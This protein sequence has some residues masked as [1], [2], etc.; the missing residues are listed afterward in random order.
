MIL[1]HG[2]S[3]ASA[4]NILSIGFSFEHSGKNWGST[5]GKGIYFTPNYETARCYAGN[6]GIVMQFDMNIENYYLL[7][8]LQR[9]TSKKIKYSSKWLITPDFDEYIMLY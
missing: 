4:L 1:Y 5:Y 6:D 9:P 2:T 8:N 3:Q 7:K